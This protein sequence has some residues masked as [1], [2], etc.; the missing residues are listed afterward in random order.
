VLNRLVQGPLFKRS[1]R[2]HGLD[3][4]IFVSS[5]AIA[6]AMRVALPIVFWNSIQHG[7]SRCATYDASIRRNFTSLPIIDVSPLVDPAKVCKALEH[8]RAIDSK[9]LLY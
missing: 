2:E 6:V 4:S 7:L 1:L 9:A 8:L 5:A 3:N